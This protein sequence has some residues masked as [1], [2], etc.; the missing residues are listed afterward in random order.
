M[1]NTSNMKRRI[2]IVVCVVLLVLLSALYVR[3]PVRKG[4]LGPIGV[5]VQGYQTNIAGQVEAL[6][7]VTNGGSRIVDFGV[8]TQLQQ[9]TGWADAVSGTRN[10]LNLT[11]EA[12]PKLAPGSNKLVSV[13]L[14]ASPSP[15]RIYVLCQKHY[16]NDWTTRLRWN[17][18]THILKRGIVEHFYSDVIEK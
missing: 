14:P 2:A 17:F 1:G 18:D 15:R 11:I 4:Y 5:T 3:T 13:V 16:P 7:A 9:P 10:N 6:V 12:D 8:G